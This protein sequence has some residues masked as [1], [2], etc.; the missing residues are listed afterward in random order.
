MMVLLAV[1]M[2]SGLPTWLALKALNRC[3]SPHMLL[4]LVVF[5]P[6]IASALMLNDTVCLLGTPL[7]LATTAQADIPAIPFLLALATSANI[8]SVMT[9]TGNPQNVI[10]GHASGWGWSG[11]ALRM[12]PLGLICLALNW[13]MLELFY[14]RTLN[15]VA[16]E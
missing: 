10:I 12:V 3:R 13:V 4:A 7:L 6:G 2:Q 1:L 11:F 15:H 14:R 9:L 16:I 5:T 8:G